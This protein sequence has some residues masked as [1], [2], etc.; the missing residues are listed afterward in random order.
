MAEHRT[1]LALTLLSAS[2]TAS[3]SD[4]ALI[5]VPALNLFAV[6][7]VGLGALLVRLRWRVRIL[8]VVAAMAAASIVWFLPNAWLPT[9][10]RLG[11]FLMLAAFLPPLLAG[12]L[13][14][15]LFRRRV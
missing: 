14:I 11:P 9:G 1:I 12:G 13:V 3:A 8:A 6:G 10:A 4:A 2:S 7:I 5:V 15:G